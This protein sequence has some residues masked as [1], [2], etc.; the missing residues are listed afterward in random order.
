MPGEGREVFDAFPDWVKYTFYGLATVAVLVFFIGVWLRGRRYWR[1][2]RNIGR[3]NHLFGRLLGA[4]RK[5]TLFRSR[6][7]RNDRYAG[8]A[9]DLTLWG[10]GVLL[11]GTILLTI[12]E[13]VTHLFFGVHFLRGSTY[14]V[15]SFAM[16]L[17]GILFIVGIGMLLYRRRRDETPRLRYNERDANDKVP[18]SRLVLDDRLFLLLLAL[19]GIAGFLAEG[20]RIYR[21]GTTFAQEWSPIGIAL[22]GL[23]GKAAM[24][25]GAAL[26]VHMVLW[27]IHAI[28]AL[29]LVAYI[30]F[31][32]AFH[33]VA[34]FGSLMFHDEN[35]VRR[36]EP[37]ATSEP[38]GLRTLADFSWVQL[39]HLDACV[40]C[41]RCDNAC[42]AKA[43][44]LPIS[45][46]GL[47]LN[48][49]AHAARLDG[50]P[51]VP[52]VGGAVSAESLWSCG[53]CMACVDA[54]P[55][56][57]EH[58][59]FIVEMRRYLVAQGQMDGGLR[60]ALT[61]LERY[62]SSFKKPAKARAKW[63]KDAPAIKDARKEPVEYLW[64]VG[65]YASYDPR[66][67]QHTLSTAK[68]L[69]RLGV[70]IGTLMDDE[71]NSGNDVR[72]IGEEGL[73]E[74]LRGEN[75]EAMKRCTFRDIIT[76]D[77]H[78]YNTLKNE[79]PRAKGGRVLHHTELLDELIRDGRLKFSKELRRRVTYHDPCYLGRYNGVYEA[80][81]NVL[82]A[83][84]AEV[85]EM[86]RCREASFCCGAG[87]G[88]IWME[89][90]PQVK[91]RPA[92]LRIKEAAGLSGVD[93][94]VVA[95]PK[96]YVMFTD[97]VKA[98]GLED[99]LQIKDIIELVGEAL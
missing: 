29:A 64:F 37:P 97:A 77:P 68:V 26:S 6:I 24:T 48:L 90:T 9:H 16:D 44:G 14:L 92:D 50:G 83:L 85:V 58:V 86:P 78:T 61:S 76:T 22:A 91:E 17:F 87:G 84:G 35:A 27:W 67:Q 31:S 2:R 63:T 1:A 82:R 93:T 54:C 65:D 33:A 4:A 55:L 96:D 3:F 10:F 94:F 70:D 59:P 20:I 56:H 40:R 80:P 36:L 11:L 62:G 12:D 42:P 57:I 15:Y 38:G 46:R 72:R 74:K 49:A 47:V 69:A 73:F 66:C 51:G 75:H 79:Y 52:A 7:W 99:R 53:T 30:P 45:P 41:G 18:L 98:A 23:F 32:K 71:R 89:E 13:D 88:R 5:L 19:A 39:M 95:C 8:V 81:R 43:S 28:G 60:G 21:D 25:E 34:G